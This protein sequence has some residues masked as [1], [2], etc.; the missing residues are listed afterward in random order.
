[1]KN[2]YSKRRLVCLCVLVILLLGIASVVS[3][4]YFSKP[5]PSTAAMVEERNYYVV[6]TAD[7][8]DSLYV[9]AY[10]AGDT[11]LALPTDT[12]FLQRITRHRPSSWVNRWWLPSCF[13]LLASRIDASA[14][15]ASRM[16]PIDNAIA[17]S[18]LQSRY[19]HLQILLKSYRSQLSEIDYYMRRHS[20]GDEGFDIVA[21][22]R[23]VVC[24]E[25]D[26]VNSL[27]LHAKPILDAKTTQTRLKSEFTIVVDTMRIAAHQTKSHRKG[28]LFFAANDGKTPKGV[29]PVYAQAS[30]IGNGMKACKPLED[31]PDTIISGKR[32]AEGRYQGVV[33][34]HYPDGSYYEGQCIDTISEAAKAS[35]CQPDGFGVGFSATKVKAGLWK[36]GRYKGEQPVYTSAHIYGIDI[37]RYQHE[38]AVQPKVRG[39]KRRRRV[40]YPIEWSK[41]RISSLGSLSK[42]RV[43]GAVDYPISF[44]YIKCSEGKSLLNRYYSADYTAARKHGY[45]V[46]AYHFFS[47][48]VPVSQQVSLF[49]R[50]CRYS[51]GDLPPALDVEPTTALINKMGGPAV[52]LSAVRKWLV[53]VEKQ[54]GVRPILYISQ[55]FINKYL[56]SKYAD[57]QYLRDNYQVWIARYGE[58]KPDVHLAIWQLSPDGRVRGIRGEVDIN[59]FNG[60]DDLFK[61]FK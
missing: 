43:S 5:Q 22:R 6:A 49:V 10:N 11:L 18:F 54:M 61:D 42:K 13:G 32:N 55:T 23:K 28:F 31:L 2:I 56:N 47:T 26:S 44:I 59:V 57:G 21:R 40:T 14:E 12:F 15:K 48:K 37:S 45:R 52:M 4:F 25:I 35:S 24:H 9:Y 41:L 53:S 19:Q 7:G 51:K 36:S 1:M 34:I 60:Y 33:T 8:S 29:C 50:N 39:R 27:L 58:Y 20:V 38:P 17:L 3:R 30:T 16:Q 46:G